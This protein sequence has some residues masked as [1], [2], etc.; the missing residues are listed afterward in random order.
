MS[1]L[2]RIEFAARDP[3]HEDHA[4]AKSYLRRRNARAEQRARM[5]LTATSAGTFRKD[6]DTLILDMLPASAPP[7]RRGDFS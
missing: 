5:G 2:S 3:R 6:G 4:E 1:F 7:V